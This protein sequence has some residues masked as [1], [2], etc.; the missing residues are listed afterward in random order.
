LDPRKPTG[1]SE[2]TRH[3]AAYFIV[4]LIR[5]QYRR[6]EIIPPGEI[7]N[8]GTLILIWFAEI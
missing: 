2:I 5:K 1:H 3:D 8:M 6:K 7:L 4:K